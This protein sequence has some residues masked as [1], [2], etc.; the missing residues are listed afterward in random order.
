MIR[1]FALDFDRSNGYAIPTKDCREIHKLAVAF[2]EKELAVMPNFSE[3]A[4][5][6]VAASMEGDV[7]KEVRG[8]L[9]FTMRP[10]FTLARFLGRA[11][12]VALYGRAN[13]YLADNGARGREALVY[14]SST[15]G[16]EQRCPEYLETLKALR[17]KP[18]DRWLVEVK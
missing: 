3:Y 4:K 10:D 5:V 8:A 13:N 17:A 15:E 11:E 14:V 1:T 16:P 18:G 7:I 12:V 2:A 6:W 9:G